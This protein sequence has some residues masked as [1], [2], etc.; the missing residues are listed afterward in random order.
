MFVFIMSHDIRVCLSGKQKEKKKIEKKKKRKKSDGMKKRKNVYVHK[1]QVFYICKQML[2]AR[3]SGYIY[4]CVY[5]CA[6]M[7]VCIV[8][9]CCA[10]KC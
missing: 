2:I 5:V 8:Y 6:C 7:Y 1:V 3:A 4:V 9:N 10:P